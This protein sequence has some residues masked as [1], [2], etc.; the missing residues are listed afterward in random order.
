MS[1]KIGQPLENLRVGCA[2]WTIP[3]QY[4]D[5]FPR[6]GSHLQRYAARLRVVEIN[7]TFYRSHRPQTYQRWA[8]TVP[9]D[10]RF[11]LKM[12]KLITHV[13]RLTQTATLNRFLFEVSALGSKLG[14]LLVQLPPS[15]AFEAKAAATFFKE[16]RERYPGSVVCEPRHASWFT[17]QAEGLLAEYQIA[18]VAADPALTATAAEPGGWKGLVY[19]RLHG[20]PRMYYSAY[21]LS[22]LEH[23][24]ARLLKHLESTPAVYCIFDN[25]AS[26]AALG[27]ALSL[28]D[29][30]TNAMSH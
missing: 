4:A 2:G 10:F 27:N 18:R 6:E 8:S 28:L 14:P 30:L 16:L 24:S 3:S 15:L 9:E 17:P 20:S 19:Y 22:F 26:G 1:S 21:P 23:L 29:L 12:L 25:T 5:R 13:H 11:A 7:S